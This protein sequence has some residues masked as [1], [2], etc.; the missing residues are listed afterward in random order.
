M[1]NS[2][3]SLPQDLREAL[4]RCDLLIG[5]EM[6]E[7]FYQLYDPKTGGFYYSIS[8]RDTK[9]MTPF[10][11]GTRFAIEAL[12]YGGLEFPEWWKEEPYDGE[13]YARYGVRKNGGNEYLETFSADFYYSLRFSKDGKAFEIVIPPYEIET[14]L[15]VLKIEPVTE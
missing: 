4:L 5:E 10:S 2:F 9:E 8:S 11:E 6:V 15:E 1:N 12:R 3:E 14:A 13:K 7:Y